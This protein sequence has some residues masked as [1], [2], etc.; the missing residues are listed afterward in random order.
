M[1]LSKTGERNSVQLNLVRQGQSNI[2]YETHQEELCS[3]G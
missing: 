3:S 2:W 1:C